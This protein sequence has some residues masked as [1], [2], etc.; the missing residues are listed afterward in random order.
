[1]KRVTIGVFLLLAA[2]CATQKEPPPRPFAGTTWQVDLLQPLPGRPPFVR[3]ADGRM[4]GHGGCN[5]IEAR[6]VQDT[7]G[8]NAIAIMR[9]D[10]GRRAACDPA[11]Q[12]AETRLLETLQAVSS[13]S[14][15]GDVMTMS[16]SAGTVR[17]R[18]APESASARP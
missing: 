5:R 9:I 11:A 4:E 12:I 1:M 18:A 6:Y 2:A 10:S 8:A 3:F 16:G 15:K 14:I 13:Y 17:L 7:V